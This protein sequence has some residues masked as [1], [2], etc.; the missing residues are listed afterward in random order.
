MASRC[1]SSWKS[2]RVHALGR[3]GDSATGERRPTM[4]LLLQDPQAQTITSLDCSGL[5][6]DKCPVDD[7]L[8]KGPTNMQAPIRTSDASLSDLLPCEQAINPTI[9]KPVGQGLC[10]ISRSRGSSRFSAQGCYAPCLKLIDTKWNNVQA[11][12]HFSSTLFQC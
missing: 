5:S 11:G 9:Q 4:R 1:L 6:V 7:N 10:R 8:G 3:T 2:S 12:E